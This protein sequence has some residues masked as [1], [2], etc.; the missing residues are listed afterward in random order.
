LFLMLLSKNLPDMKFI[1]AGKINM[2]TE[3]PFAPFLIVSTLI[4][5]LFNLDMF[6]LINLFNI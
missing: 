6:S 1:Q 4:V 3:I 2:K 5:F